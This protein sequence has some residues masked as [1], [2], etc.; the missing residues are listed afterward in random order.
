MLCADSGRR[1]PFFDD[2]KLRPMP[3]TPDM[4]QLEWQQTGS[5]YPFR[6]H[7]LS[8]GTLRFI[9]LATALLQPAR[10]STV[11]FD[12]P[13]LS[14]HPYALTLLA[15]LFNQAAES[16]ATQVI[17][18]TQSAALL[19]E[20][21]A[22]DVIV[23]ERTNGESTFRRLNSSDLRNGSRTI[24]SVNCGRRIFWE[25][26]LGNREARHRHCRRAHGR[27]LRGGPIGGV[28]VAAAG[29]SYS[30]HSRCSPPGSAEW[31][32]E[33]GRYQRRFR[34]RSFE[35]SIGDS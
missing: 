17:I 19:G 31:F 22:E 24:H 30:C 23:V 3:A 9:C 15:N 16:S 2:F 32:R 6:A 13:E 14:L 28:T 18:S 5:D 10:P 1:A 27:A 26:G 25:E 20:F 21:A 35:A 8:D 7:Q 11:L 4:I 29:L 33:S 12:E 34:H